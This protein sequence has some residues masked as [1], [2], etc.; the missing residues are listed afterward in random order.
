MG[1]EEAIRREIHE[2]NET[3]RGLGKWR[4]ISAWTTYISV[5]LDVFSLF[6]GNL[7][8][9]LMTTTPLGLFLDG[10]SRRTEWQYRWLLL[11][12]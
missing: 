1:T 10:L 2:A 12:R 9:T 8:I 11:G 3:I 4:T 6:L 7:P 5:G